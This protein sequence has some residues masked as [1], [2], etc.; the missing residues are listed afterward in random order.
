MLT[1]EVNGR[2]YQTDA[3]PEMPLL[4][5][6]RENLQLA[7]TKYGCGMELCGACTVHIDGRA[8]RS[9]RLP[10]K[11]AAGKK[12]VTIEGIAEDHPVVRAWIADEVP[13]C[14]YCHSGQIMAAVALLE[15]TPEP[16][17]AAIDDA[18]AGII[19][20]GGT[21]PR[22]RRAIHNAAQEMKGAVA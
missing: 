8:E 13:Q 1:L 14:G 15:T 21:Y 12:I 19:C 2:T 5:F 11:D 6:L 17:D 9:C 4:W 10:I 22:I 7:G 16:D 20:R 18:M 3:D